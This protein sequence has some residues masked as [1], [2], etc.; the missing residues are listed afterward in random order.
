MNLF[1][2]PQSQPIEP[3]ANSS[4]LSDGAQAPKPQLP[5]DSAQVIKEVRMQLGLGALQT[6]RLAERRRPAAKSSLAVHPEPGLEAQSGAK[7]VRIER[8]AAA[9]AARHDLSIVTS[10]IL[11]QRGFKS[12]PELAAFLQPKLA[13]HLAKLSSLRGLKSASKEILSAVRNKEPIA[14]VCDYDAD[15]TTSAAILSRFL[16]ALGSSVTVLSP[17]RAREGH[18][19]NLGRVEECARRGAK[20]LIALDF[21][22]KSYAELARAR[23]LGLRSV[24]IDHHHQPEGGPL[25][26]EALINPRQEGCGF[27]SEELCTAGLT[28][29]VT[30]HLRTQLMKGRDEALRKKAR[31]AS[32]QPLLAL[33]ALGTV[34]DVVELTPCNRALVAAGLKELNRTKIKGLSALKDVAGISQAATSQHL[35]FELGPR[36]NAL[37]RMLQPT[38]KEK[39]AGVVMAELLTTPS[40]KRAVFLANLADAK[41]KERKELETL[42][43]KKVVEEIEGSGQVPPVLFVSNQQFNGAIQGIVASRLVDR[44]NRPAFVMRS[45]SDGT[46]VG[47]ARGVPGVHLAKI[48]EK[49]KHLIVR[50]GGHPGAAGYS[51]RPENLQ[52]FEAAVTALVAKSLKGTEPKR[53]VMA[54]VA[55]TVRELNEAGPELMRE[56]G[57]LEPCGRGNSA[58]KLFLDRVTVAALERQDSKHL[59]VW[60]RQGNE[61]VYGYLWRHRSHPALAVGATVDVVARPF[62]ETRNATHNPERQSVKLELLAVRPTPAL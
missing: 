31:R 49:T 23:E 32:V 5:P 34:A 13:P 52:A 11:A 1:S 36:L 18:G 48:L 8:T 37:S 33:A 45:D 22:T 16:R 58:P 55:V 40:R 20:L 62:L 30:S 54:D 27:H 25:P 2:S 21:G 51:I 57:A 24:V 39:T 14:I 6:E 53:V 28:W 60:F 3:D 26:T 42:V 46:L 41:N 35:G 4:G 43:A 9:I 38:S 50:G 15:G 12:G 19:L 44:Y 17:D 59:K 10:R 47:S 7:L 56:F 29:L 61:Y